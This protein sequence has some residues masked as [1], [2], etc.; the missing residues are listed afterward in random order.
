MLKTDLLQ[1]L[2]V[3]QEKSDV[4][5]DQGGL[6]YTYTEASR[7]AHSRMLKPGDA[8]LNTLE[9]K[10]FA[11]FLQQS[12][13]EQHYGIKEANEESVLLASTFI[14]MLQADLEYDE[15]VMTTDDKGWDMEVTFSMVRRSDNRYF[16]LELWW[17]V[18]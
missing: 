13:S 6:L 18:D 17:S 12:Q 8:V 14:T 4:E 9:V 16:S 1:L 2:E 10:E 11:R 3:L 5:Y 15:I 7:Q